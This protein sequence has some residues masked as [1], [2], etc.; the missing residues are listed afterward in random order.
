MY[1]PRFRETYVM[2]NAMARAWA[3]QLDLF[4]LEYKEMKTSDGI[5]YQIV[6]ALHAVFK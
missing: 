6:P 1:D 3:G 5:V 4:T 2:A